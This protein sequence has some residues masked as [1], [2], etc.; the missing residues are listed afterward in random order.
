MK[1]VIVVAGP[2]AVGKSDFAIEIAKRYGLEIISGDSI[3]V[4]RGLD[5]GSGKVTEEEMQ[6]I[7]HHLIDILSPKESYSVSMF[8][9]MAR[10]LMDS[11]EK[12]MIICGGTG[13]YLKACLYDYTFENEAEEAYDPALDAYTNEQLYE[14]LKET[15]PMQ[16]AKIHPN[17]R[18]RVM[19]SLTIQKNTGKKQSD[20]EKEQKHELL[21][22]AYIIGYTMER[23]H[24]YARINKR[25]EN[26]F[27]KGLEQEIKHLLDK[28]VCF[29]DTCM[30][31]IGY[32]EWKDY[33]EGTCTSEE[34]MH[35]IQ[36]HSRNFAKRQYTWFKNQ[37]PVHWI[38]M[39]QEITIWDDLETF[40]KGE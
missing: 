26:M 18:R 17:N 22:D 33:F 29:E 21:Y 27:S 19:R 35:C 28:G 11:S 10:E 20:I 5:I 34:V 2:T 23:E 9:S 25:V 30:E 4:Y 38:D 16:A 14:M 31:G 1:K 13:L 40:L 24:L 36:K 3:Q 39:E 37:M 8:Q 15:D 7:K 32:K 6:G 12:P